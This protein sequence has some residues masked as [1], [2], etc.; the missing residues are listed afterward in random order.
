MDASKRWL[1]YVTW[2]FFLNNLSFQYRIDTVV[3]KACSTLVFL[4]RV[5]YNFSNAKDLNALYCPHPYYSVHMSENN[6][7]KRSLYGLRFVFVY[8]GIYIYLLTILN[9]NQLSVRRKICGVFFVFEI[10]NNVFDCDNLILE[11]SISVPIWT[12]RNHRI[13]FKIHFRRANFGLSDPIIIMCSLC[14][15]LTN[16]LG[17][18]F[19]MTSTRC[20]FKKCIF[21]SLRLLLF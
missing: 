14:K 13:Y 8:Q 15:L 18:C 11:F 10:F 6:P 16:H 7:F 3:A 17:H 4:K 21:Q 2:A 20:N 19:Y 1:E 5:C 12:L 9:L